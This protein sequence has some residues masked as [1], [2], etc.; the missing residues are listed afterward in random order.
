MGKINFFRGKR[1]SNLAAPLYTILICIGVLFLLHVTLFQDVEMFKARSDEGY[2]RVENEVMTEL[3]DE[4][5]PIGIKKEY[6]FTLGEIA[7]LENYLSFYVVH[8]Y[9]DVYFD[10]ELVY[11]LNLSD[12]K[13]IGK[14]T[15]SNW[16]MIPLYPEDE[17]KEVCIEITPVY[18]AVRDREVI[19]NI[20]SK[21]I[22]YLNQLKVDLPQILLSLAA[23]VVGIIFVIISKILKYRGKENANLNYLG[24]FSFAIGVWKITDIRFAP[25]MFTINSAAL[26]YISITMLLFAVVPWA[27]SIKK[28]LISKSYY[29]LEQVSI[30]ASITVFVILMLQITNVLDL[31]ETLWISHLVIAIV[32]ITVVGTITYEVMKN[33]HNTKV[34]ALKVC[35]IICGAGVII[36]MLTYYIRG[37]SSGILFTLISFLIYILTM[38]Y[39]SINEMNQKANMDLHTGLFNKGCCNEILDE[40]EVVQDRAGVI[41]FD[42]NRLKYV[43]DTFG[44]EYGDNL[45]AEFAQILKGNI[46]ERNFLGRYGGDEFIAVVKEADEAE[47]KK[48]VSNIAKDVLEFNKNNSKIHISFASG[49]ALSRDYPGYT[50]RE[51]L[52]KADQEM[53]INKETFNPRYHRHSKF[54]KHV[55]QM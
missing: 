27:L 6:R 8:Q 50:L 20:S 18:E 36:D 44:H 35:L 29:K 15:G 55:K 23:M 41:M 19:F 28:Q 16:V 38:G 47:I 34:R 10:G 51:L 31:R 52:K 9:V 2:E 40:H 45:I 53:Y 21:F 43:N 30:I 25:L 33:R 32:T 12:E 14:T 5:A 39:I 42:L 54:D 26:S 1:L 4:H 3:V 49:Y 48:L 37:N 13:Q 17:D 46:S 11:Q 24:I 22:I 7:P